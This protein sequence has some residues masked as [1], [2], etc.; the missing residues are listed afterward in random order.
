M[1]LTLSLQIPE[2][3]KDVVRARQARYV[4]QR[5]LSCPSFQSL[6]SEVQ[7]GGTARKA[8]KSAVKDQKEVKEKEV[9]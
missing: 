5:S 9:K 7:S 3:K 6:S 8:G 2:K 4:H 1:L